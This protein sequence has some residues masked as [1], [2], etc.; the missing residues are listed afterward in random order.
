MVMRAIIEESD[1]E[2]SKQM[3]MLALTQGA[4]LAH[5][6]LALLSV[7]KDLR[8]GG[9]IMNHYFRS[10]ISEITDLSSYS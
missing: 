10:V 3:Q 5:M 7:G 9:R 1:V 8:V 2:T 4:F 6:H